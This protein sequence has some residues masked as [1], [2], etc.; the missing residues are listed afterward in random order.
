MLAFSGC[1]HVSRQTGRCASRKLVRPEAAE[2]L[3]SGKVDVFA[4]NE[5][6]LFA[7]A[8]QLAGSRVLEGHFSID[9]YAIAIPKGREAGI[10]NLHKF[11]ESAKAEGLVRSA[12]GRAGVRGAI[13]E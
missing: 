3:K 11:I 8:D 4:A 13:Q 9:T 12:M 6:N 1:I 5:A 2:L 7:I 10:A